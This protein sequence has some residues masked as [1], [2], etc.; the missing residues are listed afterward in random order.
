MLRGF[1]ADAAMP[2]LRGSSV[3]THPFPNLRFIDIGA[4]LLDEMFQGVYNEK[5]RHDEDLSWVVERA[6]SCGVERVIC[7]AG[8]SADSRRALD[9][10][11]APAYLDFLSSTVGVHPTQCL[12]FDNGRGDAVIAD[13]AQIIAEANPPEG[14]KRVVALGECGLDF[15]RLHFCPRELQLVGFQMQLDLAEQVDLPMFLHNR[16]TNGE[17]LHMVR[18]NRQKMRRGGVVHSFDGSLEEMRSLT[19]ELGLHIGINGCSLRS[20]ESLRVAA[21]VPEHLLLLETDAP[22]CGIKPTHPSHAHVLT[23]FPSKKKEKFELGYMV[24]DRNEP[25][26]IRQIFEVVAAV[27]GSDPQ[28]LADIVLENTKRLFYY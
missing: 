18:G 15:A 28:A 10:V 5:K 13:L 21:A 7:T 1:A 26:T 24:K 9:L 14:P 16:E 17:F 2:L 20:E 19:E 6:K 23:T 3:A 27:R 25:C 22:W 11:S 4:N 8:T 12:E